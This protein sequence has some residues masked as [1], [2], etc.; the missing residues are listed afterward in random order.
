MAT[1]SPNANKDYN[2][3]RKDYISKQMAMLTT[4]NGGMTT[5]DSSKLEPNMASE[6]TRC[7]ERTTPRSAYYGTAALFQPPVQRLKRSRT[8][9]RARR[10]N[11]RS[12]CTSCHAHAHY[13]CR[14]HTSSV[15]HHHHHH[16]HHQ[17]HHERQDDG[18]GTGRDTCITTKTTTM[19]PPVC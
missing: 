12:T 17:P 19:H 16:H 18:D 14:P 7:L 3:N 15:S 8:R 10:L 11:S 9:Q 4:I 13:A 1:S 5:F 6:G 2:N